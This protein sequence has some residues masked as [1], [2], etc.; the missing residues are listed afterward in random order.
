MSDQRLHCW[1]WYRM[2]TPRPSCLFCLLRSDL[3]T[4]HFSYHQDFY[5]GRQNV[6]LSSDMYYQVPGIIPPGSR[7]PIFVFKRRTILVSRPVTELA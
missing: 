1:R 2:S 6:R 4:G 3:R 7:L 5:P